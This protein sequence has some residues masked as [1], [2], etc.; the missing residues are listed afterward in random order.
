MTWIKIAMDNF[1]ADT[2]VCVQY[3]V[4]LKCI[5]H[6]RVLHYAARKGLGLIRTLT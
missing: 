3:A 1:V 4:E 6:V 2:S 5:T